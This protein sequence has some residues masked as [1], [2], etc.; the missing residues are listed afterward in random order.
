M[1]IDSFTGDH[2]FLSN[3]YCDL[4]IQ[5]RGFEFRSAEHLFNALK[6]LDLVEAQHVIAAPTAAEAK[7]KGR[8]VTLRD[9]WA[10]VERFKA[11]RST[12][13]AKFLGSP[14]LSRLLVAT[15][16]AYLIEGNSWHDNTWGDCHCGRTAC[17]AP[18]ENHLGKMLMELRT[19]LQKWI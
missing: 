16:D 6:T 12:L 14:K 3:F 13:G 5:Y 1:V 4:Y 2:S 18:G 9:N 15:G 7:S 8:K 17:E 11:M 19:D 10:S